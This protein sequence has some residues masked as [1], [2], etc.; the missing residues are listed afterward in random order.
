M[1]TIIE[2][3]VTWVLIANCCSSLW[4]INTTAIITGVRQDWYNVIYKSLDHSLLIKTHFHMAVFVNW[5]KSREF[6]L[7][8]LLEVSQLCQYVWLLWEV[9]TERMRWQKNRDEIQLLPRWMIYW[10]RAE[11]DVWSN[12]ISSL[13]GWIRNH[14]PIT[15]IL[16][17]CTRIVKDMSFHQKDPL[18]MDE[19]CFTRKSF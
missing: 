12:P 4:R 11:H 19:Q 14:L 6:V 10:R 18:I 8:F 2:A 15:E 9:I 17:G 3:D 13:R 1:E 5:I 16:L 7:V